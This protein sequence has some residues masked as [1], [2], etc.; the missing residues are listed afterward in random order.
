M[1]VGAVCANSQATACRWISPAGMTRISDS[2]L[3]GEGANTVVVVTRRETAA[4]TMALLRLLVTEAE[5][6]DACGFM[7]KLPNGLSIFDFYPIAK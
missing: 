4:T 2:G 6:N 5:K 3:L 1:K 7:K